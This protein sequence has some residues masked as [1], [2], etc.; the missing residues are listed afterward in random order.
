VK[1]IFLV[2]L[3]GFSMAKHDLISTGYFRDRRIRDAAGSTV[4]CPQAWVVLNVKRESRL[5]PNYIVEPFLI[6]T[7]ADVTLIP[8]KLAREQQF[9]GY[10]PS[11]VRVTCSTSFGGELEGRWGSVTVKIGSKEPLLP[12]FY[13]HPLSGSRGRLTRWWKLFNRN[14]EETR[15]GTRP[16]AYTP[17][18]LGRAGL[19]LAG[20]ELRL[21]YPYVYLN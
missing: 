5:D 11:A 8:V 3:Y 19:F 6:D 16:L 10:D 9:V 7:G 17:L 4:D 12:C 1:P 20:F 15:P 21:A 2:N 18:V 13:Y 14:A